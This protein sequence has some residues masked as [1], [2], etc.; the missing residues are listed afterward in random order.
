VSSSANRY[1]SR[2][3]YAK[4]YRA[5]DPDD[6]V[7]AVKRRPAPARPRVNPAPGSASDQRRAEPD[8]Q[9]RIEATWMTKA[10]ELVE[11]AT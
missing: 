11:G 5:A 9:R 2:G 3:L 6:D 1:A 8:R 7:R 4:F 10:A